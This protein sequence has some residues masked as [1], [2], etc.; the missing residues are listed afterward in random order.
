MIPRRSVSQS[1]NRF[2]DGG[3][4][5]H[6]TEIVHV[7]DTVDISSE[8][9]LGGEEV[10]E[11]DLVDENTVIVE[12]AIEEDLEE[13]IPYQEEIT[14]IEEETVDDN[15][16][17]IDNTLLEDNG[18]VMDDSTDEFHSAFDDSMLESDVEE[19]PPPRRSMR[20]RQAPKVLEYQ[21][22]GVN[23]WSTWKPIRAPSNPSTKKGRRGAKR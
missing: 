1:S 16:Q 17:E 14:F 13:T 9:E 21:A 2:S 7:D 20:V 11:E 5:W 6:D 19:E 10:E 18:G 3:E 23:Q 12:E 15:E 22:M 4:E 8:S